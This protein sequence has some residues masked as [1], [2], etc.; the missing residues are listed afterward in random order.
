MKLKRPLA[1]AAAAVITLTCGCSVRS[2]SDAAWPTGQVE[3]KKSLTIS[4]DDFNK[5]YDYWLMINSIPDDTADEV[6]SKCTDKRSSI[7]NYLINE[8]IVLQQ[9]AK[10][11]ADV[12]TDEQQTSIDSGYNEFIEQSIENFKSYVN[13]GETQEALSDAEILKEAEKIFDEKLTECSMD[14]DDILMWYRNA[15][16]VDNLKEKLAEE[17][18]VEYSDAEASFAEITSGIEELYND[19]P[20]SYEADLYYRYYWLPENARMIKHILI[21]IDDSDS[22]EI[23]ACRENGDDEGADKLLEQS[24]EKIRPRIDEV[25]NMLENGGDFDEIAAEYSE[26]TG[27]E[28]NPDGYLVVPNGTTYYE[29][30]QNGAYELENVGDYKLISTDLGWHVIKYASAPVITDEQKKALTE[31]LYSNMQDNAKTTAYNEA[32]QKWREEYA[33]DIDYTQLRIDIPTETAEAS[34]SSAAS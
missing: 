23:K 11:G 4:I 32:M 6:A 33:Y 22:T 9:A 2:T 27:L 19:D 12:I 3:D 28:S 26:D 17:N 25:M 14:R 34:D 8:R 21:K 5:E 24:L 15:Q 18:P 7:I 16:I 31:A 1:A 29:G 10:V 13:A 30:F 20:S